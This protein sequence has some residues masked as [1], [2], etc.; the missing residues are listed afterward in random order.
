M[1]RARPTAKHRHQLEQYLRWFDSLPERGWLLNPRQTKQFQ[2]LY[3]AMG[4]PD[5]I[6]FYDLD[7]PD[8][9]RLI[10]S[11]LKKALKLNPMPGHTKL[12]R[13]EL[14]KNAV[15][16][17]HDELDCVQME[18][19]GNIIVPIVY[20][21][22]AQT[23]NVVSLLRYGESPKSM[24]SWASL[25]DDDM[26]L[27]LAKLDVVFLTTPYGTRLIR[28]AQCD[29]RLKHRLAE[30]LSPDRKF[31]SVK[32]ERRTFLFFLLYRLQVPGQL[33]DWYFLIQD[34]EPGEFSSQD[35]FEKAHQRAIK[36][37]PSNILNK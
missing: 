10:D 14:I 4:S 19:V 8:L 22:K 9:S 28:R 17:L 32:R 33:K 2:R 3:K 24:S 25:G 7:L 12:T 23:V 31:W 5:Y 15:S 13:D 16:L 34:V 21:T 35:A 36:K 29:P 18:T 27:K 1:R 6:E 11:A 26:I 20:G 30:A 37:L